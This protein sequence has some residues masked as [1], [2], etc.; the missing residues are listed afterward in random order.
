MHHWAGQSG[1][2]KCLRLYLDE[3]VQGLAIH[4]LELSLDI[5]H[6]D[7]TARHHHPDQNTVCGAQALQET[8]G[9]HHEIIFG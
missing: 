4:L 6:V 2:L 3:G 9:R 1:G 5:Q 8:S 7:L